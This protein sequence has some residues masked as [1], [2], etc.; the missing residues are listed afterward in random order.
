MKKILLLL[1]IIPFCFA[2]SD[3]DGN[4]EQRSIPDVKVNVPISLSYW[5]QLYSPLGTISMTEWNFKEVGYGGILVING[6][7]K[8]EIN[9]YAY[10]LSCPVECDKSIKVN[11]TDEVKAKCPNCGAIYDIYYGIGNS[12]NKPKYTLKSYKVKQSS[13][14][15][16]Y[17]T[18]E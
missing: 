17:V 5:R 8:E 11:V 15:L 13:S 3:D 6:I 18:N 2:C 12:E 9:L 1:L 4:E 10:D 7:G 14:N 16:Y